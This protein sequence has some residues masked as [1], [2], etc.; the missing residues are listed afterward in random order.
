MIKIVY[1]RYVPTMEVEQDANMDVFNVFKQVTDHEDV[2][3][4]PDNKES[5][6]KQWL[7]HHYGF[8]LI[9]DD[10]P[11]VSKVSNESSFVKYF[12]MSNIRVRI[13]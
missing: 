13:K 4:T 11:H 6:I 1:G 3:S 7:A 2:L 12:E 8:C 10:T 9:M 5:L